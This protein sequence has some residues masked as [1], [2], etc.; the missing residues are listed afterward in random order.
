MN[1]PPNHDEKEVKEIF[2][3]REAGDHHNRDKI[4]IPVS[5]DNNI[6]IS[7]FQFF[8]HSRFIQNEYL[9]N[10]IIDKITNRLQHY[11]SEFDIKKENISTFFKLLDDE[12]IEVSSDQYCDLCK[13]S[14]IFEVES[15]Q[16][17][18]DNYL[19]NHSQNTDLMINLMIGQIS[20]EKFAFFSRNQIAVHIEK[21]LRNSINKCIVNENFGKLPCSAIYRIFEKS[22]TQQISSDILYDF[23]SKCIDERFLLFCFLNIRNLSDEK[24]N[25]MCL[26][27]NDLKESNS[28]RYYD[29]LKIDFGYIKELKDDIQMKIHANKINED[30][31]RKQQIDNEKSQLQDQINKLTKENNEIKTQNQQIN[32]EKRQLQDQINKLNKDKNQAAK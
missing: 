32:E 13:L 11:Q 24:F 25:A 19:E 28:M 15:L 12:Q 2:H 10:D 16:E 3:L 6:Q 31:V 22:D 4:K 14:E 20:S 21:C 18:L 1:E 8:K 9:Q 27:Y 7:F 26:N 29:Y 5:S 30:E 17:L 23:I